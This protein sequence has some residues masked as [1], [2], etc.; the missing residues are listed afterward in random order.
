MKK[1]ESINKLNLIIKNKQK[2]FKSVFIA[3]FK[4]KLK[5][6]NILRRHV[7]GYSKERIRRKKIGLET[8]SSLHSRNRDSKY[9]QS[10]N[11]QSYLNSSM[12]NFIKNNN[13]N[14]LNKYSNL[15]NNCFLTVPS[16][17]VINDDSNI[18]LN[19][20]DNI[21][22]SNKTL[23]SNLKSLNFDSKNEKNEKLN[24][25]EY[26]TSKVFER[27]YTTVK[28]PRKHGYDTIL[29]SKELKEIKELKECSFI[30]KINYF[31]PLKN[32]ANTIYSNINRN[33]RQTN[34]IGNNY[35]RFIYS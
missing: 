5:I 22:E 3:N 2:I 12:F 10:F 8:S 16:L 18:V 31:N 26:C 9:S 20:N 32:K 28:S 25:K 14:S 11:N 24:N 13:D 29:P 6:E 35:L 17:S 33:P 23:T 1:A 21:F 27:L 34:E 4:S 15:H 7:K 30:P 19:R